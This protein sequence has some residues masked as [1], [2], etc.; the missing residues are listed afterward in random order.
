MNAANGV[1]CHY[2]SYIVFLQ[3]AIWWRGMFHPLRQTKSEYFLHEKENGNIV[4]VV[5][6]SY[7][8]LNVGN[9]I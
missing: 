2:I 3:N 6:V 5:I 1:L 9:L 4:G 7:K 8:M